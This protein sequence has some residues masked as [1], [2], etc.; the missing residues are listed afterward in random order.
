MA[1]SPSRHRPI[2]ALV[3]RSFQIRLPWMRHHRT[4]SSTANPTGGKLG[5]PFAASGMPVRHGVL[6]GSSFADATAMRLEREAGTIICGK[7]IAAAIRLECR[8][9]V[10]DLVRETGE[11]SRPGLAV[12]LVGDREDSAS[13]VRAKKLACKEIGIL[14]LGTDFPAE[15]PQE[16]L[17]AKIDELNAN[18]NVHGILVQLPLPGHIDEQAVI[19]AIYPLKDVDGLH[20]MNLASLS[21]TSTHNAD[22]GQRKL[23]WLR[24][25]E[26]PFP[27]SCTPQG[28]V[29]LLDR[30]RVPIAGKKAVVIGRSNIVG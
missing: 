19:E 8:D 29:E 7:S 27:V 26:I 5:A 17:M 23:P 3:S 22:G 10:Q 12:L 9:S 30:S 11:S 24:L 13:Y 14:D 18:P 28:C 2:R 15:V 25:A 6:G 21:T 1:L 16:K 4:M 20:P